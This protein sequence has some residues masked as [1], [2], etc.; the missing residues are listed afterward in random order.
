[1]FSRALVANV[2]ALSLVGCA[3]A[4][5]T[6]TRTG[7]DGKTVV[8]SSDPAEQARID[9]AERDREAYAKAIADAPRRSPGAPI[10][11]AV[12]ETTVAEE[13]ARS[14]D[15]KQLD[16][17]LHRELSSD[18]TLRIVSVGSLPS[19]LN[20]LGA[21]D[22]ERIDA[23]RAKGLSPDVWV[24]P[25]VLLEDT[26]G[27]SGGKLVS[28]KAFTLRSELWSAYG[29]GTTKAEAKGTVF[30]NAQVV[31]SAAARIR[32]AT[33]DELGPNLPDRKAVA[34]IQ[35]ER[36]KKQL[37]AIKE[38]AGIRPEDDTQTRLRKLFGVKDEQAQPAEQSS[39]KE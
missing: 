14:L 1:M 22:G 10:E 5:F 11:I 28:V 38:Q 37:D 24:M 20:R 8:T 12:F 3:G 29:T 6:T 25:H 16:E 36:R 33:V 18:A 32:S 31:M 21:S 35:E 2:V 15:R 27:T 30:Q 26:V 4:T 19:N 9:A 39:A 23:A 13:L 34:G 17:M 7:L